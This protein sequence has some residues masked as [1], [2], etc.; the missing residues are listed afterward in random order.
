[1]NRYGSLLLPL[2]I[3]AV[4][5]CGSLKKGKTAAAK[6]DTASLRELYFAA[7]TQFI[8][9]NYKSADSMFSRYVRGGFRTAPGYYRLA[10]LAHSRNQQTRAMEYLKKAMEAD[11]G[12]REFHM[13]E[14]D[15]YTQNRQ[16]AQAAD[17]F[18]ALAAGSPRAWT[19]YADAARFYQYAGQYNSMLDICRKWEAN[20][21]LLEAIAE[22]KS[23]AYRGIGDLRAAAGEWD[24]LSVKYPERRQ[25]RM[26]YAEMLRQ[27]GDTERSRNVYDSLLAGN[28][29]DAAVI[30]QLCR[31][32]TV[33]RP[34]DHFRW[35]VQL[36]G[37]TQATFQ[38]KMD[39]I[40]PLLSPKSAYYDSMQPLLLKLVDMHPTE[41]LPHTQLGDWLQ[42]HRRS[43]SAAAAYRK[44][45]N[46]L[47]ADMQ[48]WKKYLD[49]LSQSCDLNEL[50][51]QADTLA[52]LYP[53]QT[54]AATYR[55]LAALYT[56]A[57]DDGIANLEAA[58]LFA[59]DDD[60]RLPL[61]LLMARIWNRRGK[62][63]EA[64]RV[65]TD[66]LK[67]YPE[68]ADAA[69]TAAEIH[70]SRGEFADAGRHIGMAIKADPENPWYRL[71]HFQIRLAAGEAVNETELPLNYL[72]ESPFAL[73]AA[74]DFRQ[75][76]GDCSAA[77]ELWKKAITCAGFGRKTPVEDKIKSCLNR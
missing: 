17:A 10:A 49:A 36:S 31:H 18:A 73:E 50:S 42:Y 5:A 43:A 72:P 9:G 1:M 44:S 16:Y 62:Q 51:R 58:L 30:G 27:A 6:A 4:A 64:M 8:L 75:K 23:T 19:L 77:S 66:I 67:R 70:L 54:T 32:Y 47:G 61:Q 37:S 28:T 65:C 29:G 21:G 39:C 53:N 25:Y 71:T 3:A 69:H 76:N 11:S 68:N 57:Y 7:E 63:A 46:I 34:A 35:A 38:T 12:I 20:F 22:N 14:A 59:A 48:T 40:Q 15:I 13:L 74:G 26:I 24:R 60:Q 2:L 41:S 56:G 33:G 52:E 55:G 45:L